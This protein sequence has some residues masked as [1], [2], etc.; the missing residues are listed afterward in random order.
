MN[1]PKLFSSLILVDPVIV[2]EYKDRT[3]QV[4]F[5]AGISL[6]RQESWA[7]R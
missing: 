7:S 5:Y 4:L 3:Q 1:A 2:P 6:Q